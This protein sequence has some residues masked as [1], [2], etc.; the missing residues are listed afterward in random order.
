MNLRTLATL[1]LVCSPALGQQT[2]QLTAY[3]ANQ[4]D[5][6]G[7]SV[8]ISGNTTLVGAPYDD[9]VYVNVGTAYLF[10]T[11]SGTD[12]FHLRA[13]DAQESANFGHAVA[14]D[15]NIA[16]VSAMWDNVNGYRAGAVYLFD[17][18]T[19]Q[20]THKLLANDGAADDW[21]GRSV[22]ISGNTVIVGAP[23]SAV[24]GTT[25]GAAYLFDATTGLQLA[26]LLPGALSTN[27][28]A[29]NSVDISGNIAVVG[30]PNDTSNGAVYMYDV[31]TGLQTNKLVASDGAANDAFGWYA[32]IDGNYILIGAPA[33]EE[34]FGTS[35]Y[36]AA[37]LFDALTGLQVS[38]MTAHDGGNNHRLGHSL[39]IDGST[40]VVGAY[41]DGNYSGSMYVFDV[42]SGDYR[43]KVSAPPSSTP[44]NLFGVTVA[45]DGGTMIGGAMTDGINGSQSGSATLFLV[46]LG[47]TYCVPAVPN[48]TG[49]P[50]R[51]AATGSLD[52]DDNSLTL[53]AHNMPAN[54]FGY[55]VAS[56]NQ[57]YF[58]LAGGQGTMCLGSGKARLN[59]PGQVIVSDAAGWPDP[60]DVDLSNMPTNPHQAVQAGQTWN[61]QLWY[62]DVNPSATSNWSDAVMVVFE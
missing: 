8:A 61:F 37:Y 53:W 27:A 35:S 40:A 51:I 9:T 54:Q 59:G 60:V 25:A 58:P 56:M 29:G 10:D 22:A 31:T 39:A 42:P 5:L 20:Q 33:S 15:G 7:H 36:G 48:S 3:D 12:L 34:V 6:F 1:L 32:A 14:I 46:P 26:K 23:Y 47:R 28:T 19:G 52:V 55:Y 24:N 2:H 18:T 57:G 4:G 38:K 17:T 30:A 41:G 50:A 44:Q 16:V 13:L 21:F 62:R 45:V 43:A 11:D 49:A